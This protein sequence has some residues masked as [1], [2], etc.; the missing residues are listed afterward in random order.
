MEDLFDNL[1]DDD[2]TLY[3]EGQQLFNP[4][5]IIVEDDCLTNLGN[6]ISLDYSHI[7]QWDLALDRAIT[8]AD[9][10]YFLSQGSYYRFIRNPPHCISQGGVCRKC[11]QATNPGDTTSTVG[12]PVSLY[13]LLVVATQTVLLPAGATKFVLNTD[14]SDISDVHLYYN[15]VYAEDYDLTVLSTGEYE[16]TLNAAPVTGDV[17][18]VRMFNGTSSPFMSYLSATYAGNLLGA[19][20][21]ATGDLPIRTGLLKER[22]TESRLASLENALEKHSQHIPPTYVEYITK[23]K[24]PLERELYILALYGV[25]YDVGV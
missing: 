1:P 25:F 21:L 6:R 4:T 24:D 13:S 20:Y 3:N 14:G 17:A 18:F 15:D 9:I 7:G 2:T 19:A 5:V 12:S 16:I 22:I 10:D 23:I 11:Y 8:K